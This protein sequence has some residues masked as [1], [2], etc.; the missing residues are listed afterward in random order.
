MVQNSSHVKSYSAFASTL[1]H[2]VP[3]DVAIWE[4]E[5]FLSSS[6]LLKIQS[7]ISVLKFVCAASRLPEASKTLTISLC[8]PTLVAMLVEFNRIAATG[9]YI[10]EAGR[11]VAKEIIICAWS[12][13][14]QAS[15][16]AS[17]IKV[18]MCLSPTFADLS[19]V[20]RGCAVAL[21][22]QLENSA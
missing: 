18:A 10:D 3:D 20:R 13:C 22:H 6:E 4:H 9:I 7:V 21:S 17:K 11:R 19:F 8:A 16:Q 5:A 2:M 14:R 15:T 1:A 12:C